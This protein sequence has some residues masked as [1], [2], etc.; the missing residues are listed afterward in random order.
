[1]EN[2]MIAY[3]S[4]GWNDAAVASEPRRKVVMAARAVA[5]P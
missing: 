4:R 1:M 5:S 3:F 2:W